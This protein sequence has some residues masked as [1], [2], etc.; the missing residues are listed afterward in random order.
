MILTLTH[1][2]THQVESQQLDCSALRVFRNFKQT[3]HSRLSPF[4]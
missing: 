2:L 4:S 1:Q 3:H